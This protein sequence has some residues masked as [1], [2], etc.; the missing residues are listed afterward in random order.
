MFKYGA[1]TFDTMT[2]RIMTLGIVGSIAIL[3]IKGT[4][5][6]VMLKI[7]FLE[8]FILRVRILCVYMLVVVCWVPL[9]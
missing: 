9:C 5:Y 4:Q 1:T 7:V 6:N 3:S 2:L 8:I